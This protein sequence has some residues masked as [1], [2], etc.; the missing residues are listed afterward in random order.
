VHYHDD[1]SSP[2]VEQL[3][4]SKQHRH[5]T[6]V[7]KL[8]RDFPSQRKELLDERRAEAR[9]KRMLEL[10]PESKTLSIVAATEAFAAGQRVDIATINTSAINTSAVNDD[11][12]SHLSERLASSDDEVF[13][14]HT[15]RDEEEER[16][17]RRHPRHKTPG[18]SSERRG[19]G[20]GMLPTSNRMSRRHSND[21]PTMGEVASMVIERKYAGSSFSKQ[22]RRKI[23]LAAKKIQKVWR[24]HQRSYWKKRLCYVDS[25]IKHQIKVCV[26]TSVCRCVALTNPF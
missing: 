19:L 14:L 13:S 2:A 25:T 23:Q 9:A 3:K 26:Q 8:A 17:R 4:L 6:Q 10:D 1:H 16:R 12:L 15:P 24:R 20:G 11:S 18:I 7:Y 5:A 21:L 22:F